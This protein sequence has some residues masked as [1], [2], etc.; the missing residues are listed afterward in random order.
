MSISVIYNGLPYSIPETGE[1]GYGQSTTNYL[2]ALATGSLTLSGGNFTLEGDVNFGTVHGLTANNYT[3][4]SSFP[5]D[6]G[7]LRLSNTDVIA[8]RNLTDTGNL[9]LSVVGN[10]LYFAG[11]PVGGGGGGSSPLTTKGDLYT[12]STINDRLPVGANG[13]V[14]TADSSQPTGLKWGASGG[15]SGGSVVGF[16][17]VDANGVSGVV[18]NPTVTPTLTLTLGALTPTSV[19][20]SGTVTGSNLSGIHSGTSSGTNTGDQ[21]ITLTGD[22]TGSGTGSFATT[23]AATVPIAK[24]GTGQTTANAGFNALAPSQATHAGKV[25]ITDGADTSWASFPGAGS[26]TSVAVTP[27]NGVTASVANATTTPNISIGLGAITPTSVAASGTV[28]GSNISGTASGTNTGDQTISLTGDVT[29]GGTGGIATTLANT[30]VTPGSYTHTSITVDAKGRVTAAASGTPQTITLTGDVTGSGTGSFAATLAASGVAAGTY[31]NV[32][33]S[34]KGIVYA[35]SNASYLTGNQTITATGDATGSGTTSLPLTL[36][37]TTVSAGSY[38]NA[39]ITVDGKGRITAASNGATPGTVTSVAALTIGTTGVNI[40]SSVTNSTTTPVITLEIP[41]ASSTNRGALTSADWTTFNNKYP[42][43]GPG[44]LGTPTSGNLANCSNYPGIIA[45]SQSWSNVTSSRTSGTTYTNSTTRPIQV[46][47]LCDGNLGTTILVGS[48]TIFVVPNGSN[49][50][51]SPSFI[52]PA[53][54]TYSIT[55]A[56]GIGYWSELR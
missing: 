40:T 22:V 24:G 33:V 36:A 9:Q 34:A 23:L 20:A 30:A 8:W 31:N 45:I 4:S 2:V 49:I 46:L 15:G 1:I 56:A 32:S 25:L 13:L 50:S 54:S 18:T 44:A 38:T 52:V 48:T 17:F 16:T 43:G 53:G 29:G 42:L 19:A 55:S 3:S 37:N 27:T 26:V 51:V 14:L 11:S 21:T 6:A 28:T 7:V 12:F 5:A 35:A 47:V 10:E 41:N 39:S